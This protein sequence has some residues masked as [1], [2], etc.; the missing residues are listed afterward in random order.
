M[1]THRLPLL[2]APLLKNANAYW[3]PYS[4]YNATTVRD[5]G[6]IIFSA[7]ATG[8]AH[9]SFVVPKNWIGSTKLILYW[10][11]KTTAGNIVWNCTHRAGTPGTTIMNTNTTPASRTDALTTASK[12]GAASQLETS[13][14]SLTTTDW[15][16]DRLI[17]MDIT[18]LGADA[19]D[20]KADVAVLFRALLEYSD[21]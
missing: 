18:R 4:A 2:G 16:V 3:S 14:I 5:V 15:A 20:T 9:G 6:C 21:A 10:T 19:S 7:T 13:E 11:S 12:P 17:T 8:I 1:A